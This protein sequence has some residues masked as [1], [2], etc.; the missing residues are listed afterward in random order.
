MKNLFTST[1]SR[2][3]LGAIF[4][5]IILSF[6]LTGFQRASRLGKRS[7]AI[8]EVD[9]TSISM[10]EYQ[11]MLNRQIEFFS[12]MTG[13]SLTSQQIE[14]YG[15]KQTVLNTL[16]AQKMMINLVGKIG[17]SPSKNEVAYEI[18]N[19]PYFKKD[20]Q[21][22]VDMYKNLIAQN[23]YTAQEFEEMIADDV[24]SKSAQKIFS[25]VFLSKNYLKEINNL[26]NT[27]LGTHA[28]QI[29]KKNLTKY[30]EIP[31]AEIEKFVADPQNKQKLDQAYKENF[32]KYNTEEQIKARHILFRKKDKEADADFDK[33]VKDSATKITPA[34]FKS[35]ADKLTE[36][37]SGKGKGGDL[38][39]FSKGMMVKE[40][41]DVAFT[42][43]NGTISAPVKTKFG[44]H[45]ILV[46][47]KKPG[48]TI[49]FDLAKN[50]LAKDIIQ[51]E[52]H[53]DVEKLALSIAS[54]AKALLEKNDFKGLESLK[55]KYELTFVKDQ[56]LNLFDNKI[57]DL[58][59]SPDEAVE[60]YKN[61]T[62]LPSMEL[63]NVVSITVLKAFNKE[64]NPESDKLNS[65]EDQVNSLSS[66][67]R[68][69]VMKDMNKNSK[70]TTNPSLL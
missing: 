56:N 27:I 9:G 64:K 24:K 39:W 13:G 23:G 69:S 18:Q 17:I 58:N 26:K 25:S 33:R 45:I 51:A 21:F 8:A 28:V 53:D 15:I 49:S 47:D 48:K 19:L 44:T 37:P 42:M 54:Q 62:K 6:A 61:G 11:G 5:V 10:K 12:Q 20:N 38:S 50:E 68:E 16:V 22:N 63:K 31:K 7:D 55:T 36:D 60:I 34:N 41:E 57:G 65:E 43:K 3:L 4:G 30:I 29:M 52:K 59:L 66:Q 70:V 32:A 14:Q 46:E 2:V 35:E 1:F 67:I 40:F